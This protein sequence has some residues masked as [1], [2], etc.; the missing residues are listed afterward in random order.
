MILNFAISTNRVSL[1][2]SAVTFQQ[3]TDAVQDLGFD[4]ICGQ[5]VRFWN[6]SKIVVAVGMGSQERIISLLTAALFVLNSSTQRSALTFDA[7]FRPLRSHLRLANPVMRPVAK[8]FSLARSWFGLAHSWFG[9][10]TELYTYLSWWIRMAGAGRCRQGHICVR[11]SRWSQVLDRR[12]MQCQ[13]A[14]V[15]SG[16]DSKKADRW[17]NSSHAVS[18]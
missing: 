14:H 2:I 16:L 9:A 7:P 3:A 10:C 4:Q 11:Q 5:M 12:G 6:Q 1:S 17:R 15:G 18:K 13:I 8:F